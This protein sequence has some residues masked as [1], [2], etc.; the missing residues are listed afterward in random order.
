MSMIVIN[1]CYGGWGLS[2]EAVMAYAKLKGISL[3]TED[4]EGPYRT[5]YRH[6]LEDG[7]GDRA[8]YFDPYNI[9]RDDP[10]LLIVVGTLGKAANGPCAELK[11]VEIP[12][13]VLWHIEDYDGMEHVAEDHR[14]WG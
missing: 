13:Y 3:F 2:H 14:S 11:I 12:D 9:P 6:P 5:Y 10:A 8:D 7:L 4:T 1:K